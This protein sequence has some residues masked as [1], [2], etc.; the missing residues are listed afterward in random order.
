[1]RPTTLNDSSVVGGVNGGGAAVGSP[2]FGNG[3]N[4]GGKVGSFG[5]IVGGVPIL[6]FVF[7]GCFDHV[8]AG[9]FGLNVIAIESKNSFLR[10]SG[11]RPV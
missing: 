9:V 3:G 2:G 8:G 4:V 5:V 7:F 10:G 6:G 11:S 1:M